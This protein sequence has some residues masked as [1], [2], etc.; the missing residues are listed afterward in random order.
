M[1]CLVRE[2]Y[3]MVL[4]AGAYT[5][6]RDFKED[7][8]VDGQPHRGEVNGGLVSFTHVCVTLARNHPFTGPPWSPGKA[9]LFSE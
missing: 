3:N 2:A 9:A 5:T 1:S 7:V 8:L 4:H 6:G